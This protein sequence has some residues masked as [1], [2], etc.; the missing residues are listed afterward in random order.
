[1]ERHTPGVERAEI[2]RDS[3]PRLGGSYQV[4]ANK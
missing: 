2:V 3:T 4:S 1:M